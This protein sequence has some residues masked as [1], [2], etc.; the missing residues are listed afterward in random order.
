MI[1]G[2]ASDDKMNPLIAEIVPSACEKAVEEAC[3][4]LLPVRA[5]ALMELIELLKKGDAET[6]AKR[7]KIFLVFEVCTSSPTKKLTDDFWCYWYYSRCR[8]I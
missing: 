4:P 3:D 6:L 2:L 1:G 7:E 5:H 8:K